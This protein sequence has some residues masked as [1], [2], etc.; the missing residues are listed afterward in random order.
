[1]KVNFSIFKFSIY[2][3]FI[4]FVCF[5]ESCE[6]LK[7]SSKY[8]F[9]EGYYKVRLE[10]HVRKIYVLTGS[11]SIKAYRQAD[12]AAKVIDTTTAI[13]IA[14]P[15]KKPVQYQSHSFRRNTFD[16]DV[17]SILFKYRPSVKGF[18]PQFN[19][20]FNGA[21]Y[22]GYRTDVYNLS[23]SN[24]PMHLF[25]RIITHYGYSFGLFTGFGSARIDE[26]DTNNALSIE[27]DGLVNLSGVAI[28]L[29]ADKLTFGLTLGADHLLDKNAGVWINNGKA[30]FGLSI[31]LNL[32]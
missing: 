26:F 7:Q 2:R 23:Y 14:F 3:A 20:T 5:M 17:L 1:M 13:L 16:I 24:T 22:F 15:S 10:N 12:L 21:G 29:A 28:I 8:Q 31:G 6:T 11:D 30:W 4:V 19:A 32:N 9:N 25:R 27:Y 18:P